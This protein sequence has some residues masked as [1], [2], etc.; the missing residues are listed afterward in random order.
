[1]SDD[2]LDADVTADVDV[3]N[4]SDEQVDKYFESGGKEIPAET[5]QESAPAGETQEAEKPAEQ[6]QAQ[7]QTQ[8]EKY[9][10][11]DALHEER[12]KRKELAEQVKQ[13]ND[14]AARLEQTFQ[15]LVQN[16][17]QVS[18]NEPK[19]PSF[20]EDPIEALR[21][22]QQKLERDNQERDRYLAQQ[23]EQAEQNRRMQE[24]IGRYHDSAREYS[25]QQQD[26][27]EAYSFLEKSRMDE[28]KYAG[29]S[30]K[31]ARALLQ[32]DEAVIVAK[33]FQEGVNPAERIYKLAQHRGYAKAANEVKQVP[34]LT[35][36]EEKIAQMEKGM[37]ESKSLSQISGKSPASDFSLE[38]LSHMSE[39]ELAEYVSGK[40]WD[41]IARQMR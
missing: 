35:K 25:R 6:A 19:P 17:Q 27:N 3:S 15:K 21:F 39:D 38:A 4:I 18:A 9:V 1:M 37:Q 20:D 13:A 10:P 2:A 8:K 22:S 32:E 12:M 31:E 7:E 40:N 30:D 26:F 33:A 23:A 14:R 36:A 41:K 11:Y 28:Y 29:Y 24:F 34:S 16:A 5:A